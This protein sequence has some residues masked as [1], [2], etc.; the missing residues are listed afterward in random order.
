MRRLLSM[1]ALAAA[2]GCS[3]GEK[4]AADPAKKITWEQY[5]KMDEMD[6][7]DP[8]VLNNLDDEARKKLAE[9]AKKMKR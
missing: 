6:K 2:L 3:Q 9:Q 8:Y 4:P 7:A 5:Q 1:L